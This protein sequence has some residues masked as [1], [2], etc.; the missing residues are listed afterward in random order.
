MLCVNF[1]SIFDKT[2]IT[3]RP[4]KDKIGIIWSSFP[5]Y[6]FKLS[7]QSDAI[8]ATCDILPDASF[9]ATIF[10]IL[11]NSKQVSGFI[12]TPLLQ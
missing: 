3:P 7:L 4:P 8:L 2:E 9:I 12:L 5:E 1:G 11:D 6:I 10:S